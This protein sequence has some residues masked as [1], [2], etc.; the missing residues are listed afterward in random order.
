MSYSGPEFGGDRKAAMSPE[1]M[2][3]ITINYQIE[4]FNIIA[5]S[6]YKDEYYFSDSHN[7]KSKP[8]SL[9]NLTMIR[10][11]NKLSLKFWVRNLSDKRYEIR[12]F[13][14]VLSRQ[15]LMNNY[16]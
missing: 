3:S 13:I 10:P 16:L 14:L 4:N 5:N 11:Y 12:G 6:T 8:Y 1:L 7:E 15:I 2:G 9:S